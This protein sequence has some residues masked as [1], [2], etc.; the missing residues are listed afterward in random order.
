QTQ[1]AAGD[2][3]MDMRVEDER[4]R[5]GVEN[6]E[7]AEMSAQT[8][9]MGGQVLESSGA[10]VKE[11]FVTELRVRTD[12]GTQWI[13]NGEGD[14]EIR[15]RQQQTSALLLQPMIGIGGPAEG[16]V[17]VIARMI[18]IV[19]LA[20][21]RAAEQLAAQSRRATAQDAFEAP[22]AGAPA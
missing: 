6:A 7:H 19:E 21:I 4:A 15:D 5:P 18:A 22:R 20:A 12:P 16:T 3:V 13:G 14:Q 2:Q 9:G 8:F 11:D 10:G 1:S 17:P